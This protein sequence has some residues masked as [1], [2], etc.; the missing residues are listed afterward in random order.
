MEAP[1]SDLKT[2][3]EEI[4]VH[5][6]SPGERM[7]DYHLTAGATLA[8]L[9]RLSGTST[10]DQDVFVDGVPPEE[11]LPLHAGVVVTIVPRPR[12]SVGDEPWRA[13]IPAFQDEALFHEYSDAM[14]AL[15]DEA[16]PDEEGEAG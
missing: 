14:K 2:A 10:T 13:T 5:L 8:D 11:V 4:L 6:V 15:R 7:Q 3:T 9:L 12:Y 1:M 16:S